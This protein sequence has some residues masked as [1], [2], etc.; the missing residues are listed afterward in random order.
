MQDNLIKLLNGKI[1]HLEA[2][3]A[4]LKKEIAEY[5]R[6]AMEAHD[7]TMRNVVQ[8]ELD[9]RAARIAELEQAIKDAADVLD[10]F[11]ESPALQHLD[12]APCHAGITTRENCGRCSRGL[13]AWNVLAKIRG[14]TN[15]K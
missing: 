15:G 3:N 1:D 9:K 13:R 6:L 5:P 14:L 12:N 7:Q 8:P 4:K 10:N 11:A 2:E